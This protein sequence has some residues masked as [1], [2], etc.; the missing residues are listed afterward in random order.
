MTENASA[1]ALSPAPRI[2]KWWS[3]VVLALGLAMIV[4]DGTI[5]A[6][7]LPTIIDDL[8]LN[9][10]DAQWVNSLYA[11][12]FAALLLTTGNLGDRLRR[13]TRESRPRRGHPSVVGGFRLSH[14][15]GDARRARVPHSWT[16]RLSAGTAGFTPK[17]LRTQCCE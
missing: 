3:L 10:T 8:H 17:D 5:V 12:V 9:I 4:M 6:V 16:S 7:A 15:M 13:P 2:S 1:A 14:S 11:I